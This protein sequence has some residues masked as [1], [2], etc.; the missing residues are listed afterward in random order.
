MHSKAP[1]LSSQSLNLTENPSLFPIPLTLQF[2][3]PVLVS[4]V[5]PLVSNFLFHDVLYKYWLCQAVRERGCELDN[6]LPLAP[7][8]LLFIHQ[9]NL[10]RAVLCGHSSTYPCFIFP[11]WL[12]SSDA[13]SASLSP[14]FSS[15][16]LMV[17]ALFLPSLLALAQTALA[18]QDGTLVGTWSTGSQAVLTGSVS[19]F[20]SLSSCAG[21][22]YL[23]VGSSLMCLVAGRKG[24]GHGL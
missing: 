17:S 19:L 23:E 24:R 4:A 11:R 10:S 9:P 3:L 13:H 7:A 14:F 18:G 15:L 6:F 8:T 22:T 20:L 12:P 21:W 1:L 5:V 2:L 16:A